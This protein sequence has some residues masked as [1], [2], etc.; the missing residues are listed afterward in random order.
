VASL[1]RIRLNDIA[2]GPFRYFNRSLIF[3]KP[4]RPQLSSSLAPGAPAAPIEPM[5][6]SFRNG[7]GG[8]SG[9]R[10]NNSWNN[11]RSGRTG[12]SGNNSYATDQSANRY[13]GRNW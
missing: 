1:V 10:W 6:S 2:E 8:N 7:G 5:I 3:S 12:T 9:N 11:G 13:F 4:A